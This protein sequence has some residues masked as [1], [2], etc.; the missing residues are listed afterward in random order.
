MISHVCSSVS[1]ILHKK[2]FNRCSPS[3]RSTTHSLEFPSSTVRVA[4]YSSPYPQKTNKDKTQIFIKCISYGAPVACAGEDSNFLFAADTLRIICLSPTHDL[5]TPACNN[6]F[7][8]A[9]LILLLSEQL[10]PLPTY[11]YV[12]IPNNTPRLKPRAAN[13]KSKAT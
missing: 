7:C 4:G 12:C 8:T 9:C 13:F 5:K 6:I 3:S 2:S 11:Q 10:R 1:G